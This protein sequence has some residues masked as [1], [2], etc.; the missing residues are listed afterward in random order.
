VN[1]VV[2]IGR[3]AK[4]PQ[5]YA[6][7]LVRFCLAVDRKTKDRTADFI[8]CAAFEKVGTFITRY[9]HKGERIGIEGH[10]QTGSYEKN[11]VKVY[12]TDVIVDSAEFVERRMKQEQPKEDSKFIPVPD[13]MQGELPFV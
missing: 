8:T 12:T 4:D 13:E 2:L 1:K 5:E 10:I 11:G 6:N 3:L 7:G 9:F